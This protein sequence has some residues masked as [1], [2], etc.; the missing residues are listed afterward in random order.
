MKHLTFKPF[1]ELESAF[2]YLTRGWDLDADVSED[3]G[4]VIVEIHVAGINPDKI[5]VEVHD[6]LLRVS[7]TREEEKEKKGRHYF[8]R[9][10]RLGDF[11]RVLMLPCDVNA[12]DAKATFEHGVLKIVLQKAKTHNVHKIKIKEH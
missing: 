12:E 4:N 3:D 6:N 11:E 1:E 7:G 2:D 10:I 8:K 5:D 9:E